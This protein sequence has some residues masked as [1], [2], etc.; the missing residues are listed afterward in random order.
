M[1]GRV[2]QYAHLMRFHKPIGILLLLWPVCWALW[3]ASA[4]RPH[5]RMLF[6]F[7]A[8]VIVM[9]AAGCVMNDM[10]D[11][12]IDR[13][14]ERTRQRP[15]ATRQVSVIE[16]S[17]LAFFLMLIAFL[18]VLLCN[19]LT[20]RLAFVGAALAIIYPFM[21]RFTH[22]PQLGLGLA[23]SW[24]IPMVFAAT[25]GAISPSAWFLF[26]T[27]AL[28]PIL[29][30]TLYAMVDREDDKKI[31][32]KSTAI[33]FGSWDKVMIGFLQMIF[34]LMLIIVGI[35]F[36][37]ADR[38]DI[39]LTLVAGLFLYQQWLIKDRDPARCFRA[40]LNHQWVGAI[41]FAGILSSYL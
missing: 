31:G 15:M 32:V 34:I 16:A 18:F 3:L 38:Y 23:F 27:A 14:V 1:V 22:W 21:K 11:R 30:D 41:I 2:I 12:H 37:L 20:I 6:V 26:L 39:A 19:A 4:G 5:A 13:H 25:Q 36:H 8:G 17:V 29:Y 35:I 33:L 24:S 10:A 7:I 9:R 28:W 40:F